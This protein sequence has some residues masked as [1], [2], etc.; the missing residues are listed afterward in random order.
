MG[1]IWGEFEVS[2]GQLTGVSYWAFEF[3]FLK[4]SSV[5]LEIQTWDPIAHGCHVKSWNEWPCSGI[6]GKKKEHVPG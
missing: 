6:G 5:G 1:T 4:Q 3:G 2:I